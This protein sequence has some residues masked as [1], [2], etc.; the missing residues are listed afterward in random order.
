MKITALMSMKNKDHWDIKGLKTETSI[1]ETINKRDKTLKMKEK[2]ICKKKPQKRALKWGGGHMAD[3]HRETGTK[4]EGKK[5]EDWGNLEKG[6]LAKIKKNDE[7]KRFRDKGWGLYNGDFTW[8]C[9]LALSLKLLEFILGLYN[10]MHIIVC[11]LCC[12]EPLYWRIKNEIYS[13][14]KLF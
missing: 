14:K 3:R 7:V 8:E 1:L 10:Y 5:K 9:I 4:L 2:E 13:I 12:Y 11:E 6:N